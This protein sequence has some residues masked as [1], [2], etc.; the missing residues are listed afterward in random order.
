MSSKTPVSVY[1]EALYQAPNS[2]GSLKVSPIQRPV[3][4]SR[5]MKGS[6]WNTYFFNNMMQVY[7]NGISSTTLALT[8]NLISQKRKGQLY[9][10]E[11][12]QQFLTTFAAMIA[13]TGGGTHYLKS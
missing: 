11:D 2:D 6:T 3:D 10:A 7:S 13:Y 4:Q 5:Y 1:D 12:L 8:R 9:F